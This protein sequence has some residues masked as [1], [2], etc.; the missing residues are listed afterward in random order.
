MAVVGAVI[1]AKVVLV[2]EHVPL[3]AWL[4][5]RPAVVDVVLRTGLYGLGVLV[6]LVLEKAFET[7]HEFGGFARAL[8]RV[9]Q[10]P[11][12]PHVWANTLCIAGALLVFNAIT[13]VRAVLG[14][15]T[16]LPLFFSA[17][18]TPP[19]RDWRPA[20]EAPNSPSRAQAGI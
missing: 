16:L 11:D 18:P 3:G 14:A 1:L 17:P 6:V 13:V 5:R 15:P 12:M 20:G 4:R 7:R 8:P 19:N 9:F 10:H 2:L